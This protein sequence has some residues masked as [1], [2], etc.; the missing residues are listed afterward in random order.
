MTDKPA[1]YHCG[2]CDQYHDIKWDGDCREDVARFN[3]E[4][5]DALYGSN[6]WNE[7]NMPGGEPGFQN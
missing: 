2:I 5:L 6:G 4:V 7:V 3:P 1:Y